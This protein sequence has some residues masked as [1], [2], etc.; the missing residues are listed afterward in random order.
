M[1]NQPTLTIPVSGAGGSALLSVS[2]VDEILSRALSDSVACMFSS[3]VPIPFSDIRIQSVPQ[4]THPVP[5]KWHVD[6]AIDDEGVFAN[7]GSATASVI[8]SSQSVEA[9]AVIPSSRWSGSKFFE[10]A[11]TR[12][13]LDKVTLGHLLEGEAQMYQKFGRNMDDLVKTKKAIKNELKDYDTAFRQETG[14]DPAR[15]DK[16][17]MRLLY[18]LYR[19][20]RDLIGRFDSTSPGSM[21]PSVA[22]PQILTGGNSRNDM[23]MKL[24]SLYQEKQSIRQILQEYQARFMAEQGRRIKYHRDIVAVDREYRQYKVI[25]EEISK[26]ESQLGRSPTINKNSNDLFN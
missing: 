26:L 25:K 19:K 11:L 24:E 16:E 18:T 12:L 5:A 3:K 2:P 23:E 10:D 6:V 17:P 20:L 22:A 7:D 1:S 14:R 15:A 9:T 4:E 13:S 21:Q 8:T